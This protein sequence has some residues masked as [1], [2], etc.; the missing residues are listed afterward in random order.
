M[1]ARCIVLA[2]I[3]GFVSSCS[4]KPHGPTIRPGE[5]EPK[6]E[7]GLSE[8]ECR[9]LAERIAKAVQGKDPAALAKVFDWDALIE[10]ASGDVEAPKGVKDRFAA[11]MKGDAQRAGALAKQIRDH[12]A[13]GAEYKY[14]HAHVVGNEQRLLFRVAR[15]NLDEL[16]IDYH[17]VVLSRR[18]DG[19]VKAT[20]AYILANGELL[21]MTA[22]RAFAISRL[23]VIGAAADSLQPIERAYL[24]HFKQVELMTELESK[25]QHDKALQIYD[26]L[27]S[28]LQRDKNV[29]LIRLR[30]AQAVSD[31]A[32]AEAVRDLRSVH[33]DDPCIDLYGITYFLQKK[34]FAQALASIDRIERAVEDTPYANLLRA[35][36]HQNAGN[37][38]AAR[39][40][41]EAAVAAEP[42]LADAHWIL[43][44]VSLQEKKHAETLERLNEIERRFK[45]KFPDFA[46]IPDYADFVKSP[47]YREWLRSHGK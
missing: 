41:A 40:A 22:R 38:P 14:L 7:P 19:Q 26:Q 10:N 21:S 44:L 8:D 31:T 5:P 1:C 25:G 20:D 2:A 29:L 18:P 27:P 37:W 30:A 11:E 35:Y 33:P 47:Q 12:V 24:L 16:L 32:Y 36:V 46:S 45:P 43:V 4:T 13:R 15:P 42:T 39:K 17:D 9:E 28:E 34:D 23:R 3:L 6:I